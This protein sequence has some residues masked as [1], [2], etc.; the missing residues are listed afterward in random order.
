M[1]PRILFI[2]ALFFFFLWS[3]LASKTEYHEVFTDAPLSYFGFHFMLPLYYYGAVPDSLVETLRS[4]F[5]DYHA[6]RDV[7]SLRIAQE[8]YNQIISTL[9][10]MCKELCTKKDLVEAPHPFLQVNE[11]F[12]A[13]LRPKMNNWFHYLSTSLPNRKVFL[14]LNMDRKS[15]SMQLLEPKLTEMANESIKIF[16]MLFDLYAPGTNLN[17]TSLDA[18]LQAMADI[19][20][21]LELCRMS[22]HIAKDFK[23]RLKHLLTRY[24]RTILPPLNGVSVV[25]GGMPLKFSLHQMNLFFLCRYSQNSSITECA[26]H[27]DLIGTAPLSLLGLVHRIH[28]IQFLYTA[29]T[30]ANQRFL[31]F[32]FRGLIRELPMG[33]HIKDHVLLKVPILPAYTSMHEYIH[34]RL[35]RSEILLPRIFSIYLEVCFPSFLA[36][37]RIHYTSFDLHRLGNRTEFR[38][39]SDLPSSLDKFT[40]VYNRFNEIAHKRGLFFKSLLNEEVSLLTAFEMFVEELAGYDFE[41]SFELLS[42]ITDLVMFYQEQLILD[43]I[44][45]TNLIASTFIWFNL[46]Y[47]QESSK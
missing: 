26:R 23:A 38:P 34:H 20:R 30:R 7:T 2:A 17:L 21:A 46:A 25:G 47:L 27:L 15:I 32:L 29:S 8:R 4:L 11:A 5:K 14:N 39:I 6:H 41:D 22:E 12:C 16:E 43:T 10:P 33:N 45:A 19:S 28:A 44:S 3:A 31:T 13:S 40:K 24:I 1:P 36:S 18:A 9:E 35:T 42:C 37:F